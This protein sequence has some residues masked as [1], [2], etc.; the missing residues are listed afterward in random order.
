MYQLLTDSMTGELANT[1]NRLADN[2]FIPF[3]VDNTDYAQFKQDL[4]EGAE[5]QDADGNKMTAKQV[6]EF[7]KTLQE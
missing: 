4:S 6:A 7:V 2:A 1:V 3:A 5:L